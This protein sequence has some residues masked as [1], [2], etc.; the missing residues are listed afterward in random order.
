MADATYFHDDDDNEDRND[1]LLSNP[2]N[3][4]DYL[5]EFDVFPSDL[6][7]LTPSQDSPQRHN[8]SPNQP[9]ISS[10][11]RQNFVID[12]FRQHV[13]QSQSHSDFNSR[14]IERNEFD[15]QFGLGLGLRFHIEESD[16]PRYDDGDEFGDDFFVPR[17]RIGR[18][19]DRSGS[20]NSSNRWGARE[21]FIGGD[22]FGSDN[23]DAG[24][25]VVVEVDDEEERVHLCL[26]AFNLED[27]DDDVMVSQ[28]MNGNE[29]F[30]WEEVNNQNHERQSLSMFFG[31]EA[32]E[33]ASVIPVIPN[34]VEE[35]QWEVLLNAHNLEPNL[36]WDD[37]EFDT[38][39]EMFF[40]RFADSGVS[41]LGRPPASK[42]AIENLLTVLMTKEDAEKNNMICA[43][44]KDEVEIGE[45]AT[46]LPCSHRYHGDC[47]VPWLGIRN[48]CP[49]CRY[50]LQT[51]D[52]DSRV[53]L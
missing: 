49:V 27:D 19:G 47:I 29:D 33:D 12:M 39:Y 11:N 21:V 41:S 37:D 52:L 10:I 43:I 17:R 34:G 36:D 44:C 15:L 24:D 53:L 50:E 30:E 35:S 8:L 18:N 16:N 5:F 38:E 3:P 51:D 48:T 28:N 1:I 25:N 42:Q 20:G 26:S 7:L 45:M 2:P 6:D 46:Q 4:N 14:V 9:P 23:D 32:D 40:G 13:D 22:S 31:S